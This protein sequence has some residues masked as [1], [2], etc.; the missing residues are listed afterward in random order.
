MKTLL[1]LEPQLSLSLITKYQWDWFPID[2]FRFFCRIKSYS[3][4]E[5][6]SLMKKNKSKSPRLLDAPLYSIWQA[7]YLAFFSPTLY[8]DVVKRWRGMVV[9][10]LFLLIACATL[11]FSLRLMVVLDQYLHDQLIVPMQTLPPLSIQQ[12]EIS[13]EHLMPYTLS[14]KTGDIVTIVDTTGRI[15]VI[16]PGDYPKLSWLITKN[17]MYFRNP[18]LNLFTHL[19]EHHQYSK[20]FEEPLDPDLTG[21]FRGQDFLET[22]HVFRLTRF[23]VWS[24]Y[25]CMVMFF[26]MLIVSFLLPMA[27]AAQLFAEMLFKIKLSYVQAFRLLII[28]STAPITIAFGL[29]AIDKIF[30]GTGFIYILLLSAYF[31]LGMI[32][33]KHANIKMV[34]I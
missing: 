4:H 6:D 32:A 24:V 27:W 1:M 7:L 21:V 18:P 20:I 5:V 13:F 3:L 30:P 9:R 11:P 15:N 25:P 23:I 12:G 31:S 22:Y 2:A 17:K 10:Y 29:M 26:F 19:A 34:L 8:V 33:F 28:A 14:N 16:N